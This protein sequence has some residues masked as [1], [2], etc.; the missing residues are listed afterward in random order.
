MT[1]NLFQSADP[2]PTF[3]PNKDYLTELVGDDKKFKTP[4]ELARSKVEADLFIEQLKRETAQLRQELEGKLKLDDLLTRIES[5]VAPKTNNVMETPS[6]TNNNS[7]G[8]PSANGIT[9][10]EIEQLLTQREKETI[11]RNNL[12]K[13][14]ETLAAKYGPDF[15]KVVNQRAQEL[16]LDERTLTELAKNKPN[17]FLKLMD[18]SKEAPASEPATVRNLSSLV[19]AGNVNSSSFSQNTNSGMKKMSDFSKLRRENPRLYHSPS[20]QMEIFELTKKYGDAFL[21]S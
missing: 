20:T 14:A 13:V 9:K 5:S 21:N 4:A 16:E 17:S 10:E 18:V 2:A 12:T 19:P 11:E 15:Q 8:N 6:G 7:S 3:D 1:V